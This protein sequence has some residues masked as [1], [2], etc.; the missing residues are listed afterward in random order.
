MPQKIVL[1]RSSVQGKIPGTADLDLGEIAINTYDGKMFIKKNDGAETVV[2]V[3]SDG[4]FIAIDSGYGIPEA[5][6]NSGTVGTDAIDFSVGGVGATGSHSFAVG[7][8]VK[9][10][11]VN[12][13]A[14]GD[15]YGSGYPTTASGENTF[16]GGSYAKASGTSSFAFGGGDIY[17]THEA[18]GD[19]STVFGYSSKATGLISFAAGE[20]TIASG[21]FSHAEGKL[22]EARGDSSHAEGYDVSSEG[23]YSHAEGRGTIAQN[24]ASHAE[25]KYNV[26]AA[27][28]TIHETGIGVDTNNRKNAFEIYTDGKIVAPE[29][30]TTL[31]DDS[32]TSARVLVT[33]EWVEANAGGDAPTG[34]EA[35]DEGNGIGW[36]L[37]GRDP[38]NY[39]NIGNGAVDFSYSDITSSE[40]GATGVLSV[41]YGLD[42]IAS[43]NYSA[44]FGAYNHASGLYSFA[45]GYRTTASGS[46][47]ISSGYNTTA[48]G[49]YSIS[50]GYKNTAAGSYGIAFGYRNEASGTN[51]LVLGR[52]SNASGDYSHAEGYYINASNE[53]QIMFGKYNEDKDTSLFE[54][55]YG[56]ADDTR[57][58][59]FEVQKT[60]E[61]VA[62]MVDNTKIDAADAKVLVT[63]EWVEAN[64]GG[65]STAPSGLEAIDE[66]NGIGWR[67]IGRNPDNYGNIGQNAIDFSYYYYSS[68]TSGA[69]GEYSF[70]HG[71]GSQ[72]SGEYSH[73][74]GYFAKATG[75]H[76][77]AF[78]ETVD[79]TGA[80]HSTVIGHGSTAS[81]SFSLV[82]GQ[83]CTAS[84]YGAISFG[85]DCT[86]SGSR[87][88]SN[89]GGS[90]ASGDY[91]TATGY[92]CK[93]EG[94]ASF[95]YG[96]KVE[97]T[98]DYLFAF[99]K[100]NENKD[101]SIFE[102]GIGADQDHKANAFEIQTTGEVIAPAVDNTKID[103][104]DAKV[105]VTREWVEANGGSPSGLE[106]ITENG[107]TGWRLI[108]RDPANYGD[109]G[110]Q[111][112]DFSYSNYS[113]DT[114]GATGQYSVAFGNGSTASGDY[115][116]VC[117]GLITASG[118][119][120]TAF[121]YYTVAS[122]DYSFATGSSQA[123]GGYS[124]AFCSSKASG[125][126][127]FSVNAGEAEGERSF[128]AG[129]AKASGD[130]SFA[131]GQET[132]AQN[133]AS[134][135]E[136]KYNVGTATDTIHETGIGT[137]DDQRKNAFEIYT[138]GKVVA[139]ELTPSLT[140]T[141]QQCLVPLSYLFSAEFGN[142]LPT[143][144]GDAGTLYK[145]ADGFVKVS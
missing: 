40:H 110:E 44:T 97:T 137:A 3:G 74:E 69:T 135:A 52:Y 101:T 62:P 119:Y 92:Y 67:L 47:S 15:G 45:F 117:G 58:N 55:G 80:S 99:G 81:G 14:M 11:G 63:R 23:D 7:S 102:I 133:E 20:N 65:S 85:Y 132:I 36:R 77:F 70:A 140:A 48:S 6:D 51:S 124:V 89:G 131:E 9:A 42:T 82:I 35:I 76:G 66:G 105:L 127:S 87:S 56:T 116:F 134:H 57:A 104:A 39:G 78:G 2:E 122:G 145:D 59:I 100:N 41:A 19:Y 103:A 96:Y 64:A 128:A 71:Y 126:Q 27:T 29:L 10:S 8:E 54:L 90:I 33:R 106:K 93:A 125:A 21:S 83:N 43:G 109:I 24:E 91:S 88:Y 13:F 114:S 98:S 37:I 136:G 17:N 107:H 86:S 22:T 60:G 34:L 16:A 30:T 12:S 113:N 111:A 112:V 129:S 18:S 84:G 143:S 5:V 139:P 49:S 95:A 46:H 120:S 32:N 73:A 142:A 68:D 141:N 108:G 118:D 53:Y 50:A 130:F 26:G 79:A 25:G 121:G 72:A 61:V 123:S 75:N 4:K 138:D 1:K 144:P 31:I 38:D 115:S 94:R 28:D